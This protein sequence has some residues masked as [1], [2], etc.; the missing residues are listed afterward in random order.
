MGAGPCRGL[1]WFL[2]AM[3]SS[4]PAGAAGAGDGP[5]YNSPPARRLG[6][7]GRDHLVVIAEPPTGGHSVRLVV[8]NTTP[9]KYAPTQEAADAIKG[10]QFGNLI[11][12]QT[13]ADGGAII[14]DTIGAWSPRPGEDTPHG[15]VFIQALPS[16]KPA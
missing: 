7:S 5:V 16:D 3:P 12:V 15:Y 8:P 10:L 2:L 13:H 9:D 6:V 1:G 14:I 4:T 11:Q